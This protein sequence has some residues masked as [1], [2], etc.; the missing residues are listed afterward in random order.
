[1]IKNTFLVKKVNLT[2]K[3][4]SFIEFV[5]GMEFPWFYQMALN[6]IAHFGHCLMFRDDQKLPISGRINSEHYVIVE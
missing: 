4:S 1:M 5:L 6:D 2:P 3:E